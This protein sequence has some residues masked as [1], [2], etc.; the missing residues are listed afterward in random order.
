MASTAKRESEERSALREA[1][2]DAAVRAEEAGRAEQRRS[3]K[4]A[5]TVHVSTTN[6]GSPL[7]NRP[8][9]CCILS[10][11]ASTNDDSASQGEVSHWVTSVVRCTVGYCRLRLPENSESIL[12]V[13]RAPA[14]FLFR[15]VTQGSRA[16]SFRMSRYL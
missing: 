8:M 6:T 16:K 5:A 11:F 1:L 13:T 7:S 2:K 10:Y 3:E 14:V 15:T 4:L 9:L 12:G